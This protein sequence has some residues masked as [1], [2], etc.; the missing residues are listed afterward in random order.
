[1]MFT[2]ALMEHDDC[3]LKGGTNLLC[4]LKNARNTLDLDLF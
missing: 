4:R 3:V 2:N 1:M